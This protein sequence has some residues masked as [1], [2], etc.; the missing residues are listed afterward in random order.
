MYNAQRASVSDKS[1]SYSDAYSGLDDKYLI[2]TIT[3]MLLFILLQLQR[4]M[5]KHH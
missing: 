2:W 4:P 5:G 1:D 3:K